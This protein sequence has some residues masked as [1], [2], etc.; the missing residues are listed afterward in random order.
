MPVV[1]LNLKRPCD[2]LKLEIRE[3]FLMAKTKGRPTK[4]K[5]EYCELLIKHMSQ[6]LSFESFAAFVN[7]NPDT[8]YEWLKKNK[9][10]KEAYVFAK[11]KCL[12]FW[13][14]L[15][16]AGAAGKVKCFN[17]ATWI[18]NMKNRFLWRDRAELDHVSSDGSMTPEDNISDVQLIKI[19]KR[20]IEKE[21]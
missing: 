3:G 1:C 8:I 10:F 21:K 15:G 4:Y 16:I 18:F 19:A 14:K 11:I 6:G 17:N 13:E 7:V 20:L 5:K 12:F 2:I 9:E